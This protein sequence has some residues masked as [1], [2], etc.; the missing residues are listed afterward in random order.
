MASVTTRP[1]AAGKTDDLYEAFRTVCLANS[2]I[3][4]PESEIEQAYQ[5]E[6][7][8]PGGKEALMKYQ[9]LLQLRDIRTY[10]VDA[11][12]DFGSTKA[13]INADVVLESIT[14]GFA[15]AGLFRPTKTQL[16]GNLLSA[17][18]SNV[19]SGMIAVMYKRYNDLIIEVRPSLDRPNVAWIKI[20]NALSIEFSGQR[21]GKV[22]VS[23]P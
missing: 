5:Q 7:S 11:K 15:F 2:E 8:Q 16:S 21:Y 18:L 17:D 14:L 13:S 9:N 4:V 19:Q 22:E 23:R 6:V 12:C 1:S 20:H 3:P 10:P